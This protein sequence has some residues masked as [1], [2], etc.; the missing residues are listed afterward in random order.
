MTIL[1]KLARISWIQFS[2]GMGTIIPTQTFFQLQ[3]QEFNL[4]HNFYMNDYCFYQEAVQIPN[5]LEWH[6]CTFRFQLLNFFIIL[7]L[8]MS[9]GFSILIIIINRAKK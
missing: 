3:K 9:T 5:F 2:T 8:F 4:K 1:S 7:E 6:P